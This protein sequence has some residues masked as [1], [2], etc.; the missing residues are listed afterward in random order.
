M[1]N[2]IIFPTILFFLLSISLPA[3][4]ISVPFDSKAWNA[5]EAQTSL[6]H[7]QGKKSLKLSG[8]AIRLPEV[9]FFN[10]TIKVDVNFP[11]QR[12]F[13]GILFRSQDDSNTEHFYLRPHQSGKPDACQYTPVFNGFS[14][15]QLYHGEDF[16][17]TIDLVP[18]QWHHLKIVVKGRQAS[19]FYDDM[20]QPILEI[21]NLKGDFPA[22]SIGLDTGQPVHFANFSY[23]LDANSYSTPAP[24]LAEDSQLITSW[25]L[26]QAVSNEHFQ[27]V[28][29]LTEAIH[30]QLRWKTY[31]TETTGLMNIARH[32]APE[33]GKTT[34]VAKLE[35]TAER[36][37]IKGLLFGYSD[38]V[39]VFVN[40]KL[41]YGGQNN[42][43]SR[44][45]RYLGT[46]GFFDAVFLDLKA[47]KNEVLFVVRENFGGWGLQ[48]RWY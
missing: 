1:I 48:A 10:G 21:P 23:Q 7:Y 6:E 12:N 8:G 39:L 31:P 4:S 24:K 29:V 43:R 42:Y 47:G 17:T 26:S 44:D 30:K 3:Q 45:Y 20:E 38:Q 16:G 18:D 19:V 2:R 9:S 46:I 34:V 27:D 14:G 28:S 40:G 13:F 36:D 5:G 37:E 33:E 11:D 32:V 41:Q 22:G 35:V 25:Q 15:W